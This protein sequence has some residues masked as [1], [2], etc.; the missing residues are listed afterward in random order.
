[1]LFMGIFLQIKRRKRSPTLEWRPRTVRELQMRILLAQSASTTRPNAS[2]TTSLQNLNQGISN[3]FY[4]IFET[5]WDCLITALSSLHMLGFYSV[6]FE[7]GQF[8]LGS[9]AWS[10]NI[11][12]CRY[13]DTLKCPT[14][15]V[16]SGANLR[17]RRTTWAEERKLNVETFGVPGRF[18]RGRGFRG[19]FRGRRGR[20]MTQHI[21]AQPAVG[22]GRVW[23]VSDGEMTS[24]DLIFASTSDVTGV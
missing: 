11:F 24:H 8:H 21:S 9:V 22:S 17:L 12:V 6:S 16:N 18:L 15:L 20:G 13:G 2:L 3:W 5:S 23:R 1:M 10:L 4:C 7:M 19:G 14:M